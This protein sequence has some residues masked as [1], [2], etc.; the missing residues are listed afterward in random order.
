M[1]APTI[2]GLA[3]VLVSWGLAARAAPP[4]VALFVAAKEGANP[5][6]IQSIE[7]A[8]I[9]VGLQVPGLTVISTDV[10]AR[11]L[12]EEPTLAISE[13]GANLGC[14]ARLGKR[15]NVGRVA[16]VRVVPGEAG[17]V[18]AHFIGVNTRSRALEYRATLELLTQA[19]VDTLVPPVARQLCGVRVAAEANVDDELELVAPNATEQK[20]APSGGGD[21]LELEPL[22][23]AEALAR[24]DD[25]EARLRKVLR[26]GGVSAAGAGVLS[27][28]LSA[29]FFSSGKSLRDSIEY[30]GGRPTEQVE[31]G[32]LYDRAQS[33]VTTAN[34]FLI[35]GSVAISVGAAMLGYEQWGLAEPPAP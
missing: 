11:R 21:D 16:Y 1:R 27:L 8:V 32:A 29:A 34:V 18:Q 30:G 5:A 7:A 17:R 2:A 19:D 33:R 9:A 13:C 4:A 24:G 23:K 28:G 25:P 20:L 15:A 14:I 31:A 10:L 26:W 35:I 22:V 3:A 12:R 6:I